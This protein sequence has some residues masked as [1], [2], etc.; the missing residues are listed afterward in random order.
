M[1]GT[2]FCVFW[3]VWFGG[4]LLSRT[5]LC[6]VPWALGVLAAGFG[7]GSGRVP[8]AMTTGPHTPSI[9]WCLCLS[10]VLV[11]FGCVCGVFR[12]VCLWC[13]V[14]CVFGWVGCVVDR[15]VG[16]SLVLLYAS[17]LALAC[18]FAC[19]CLC[20]VCVGLLVP[21]GLWP[22][23]G[24]STSGLSTQWSAGDLPT[25]GG[26]GDLV[27]KLVSRLDAFSGYPSRT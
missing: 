25:P 2:C 10:R 14:S 4:V 16:V 27:L 1:C 18:V 26:C 12:S 6:A 9:L 23:C 20:V 7:D 11:V 21:V 22:L 3:G 15:I 13:L 19:S 17:G 24:L 8:P 5:V